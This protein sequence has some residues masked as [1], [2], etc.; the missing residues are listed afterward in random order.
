MS[1]EPSLNVGFA[2]WPFPLFQLRIKTFDSTFSYS[3]PRSS[4]HCRN[5]LKMILFFIIVVYNQGQT[6]SGTLHMINLN[7]LLNQEKI[8]QM[9]LNVF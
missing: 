4:F 5:F 9:S 6:P 2:V 7:R 3:I 8:S 1:K